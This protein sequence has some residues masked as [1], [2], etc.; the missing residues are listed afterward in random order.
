MCCQQRL[1][2]MESA[3]M[4]CRSAYSPKIREQVGGSLGCRTAEVR[5][6]GQRFS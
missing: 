2:E 1:R 3:R 6:S 4:R 5:V